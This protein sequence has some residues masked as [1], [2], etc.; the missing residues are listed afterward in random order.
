VDAAK[1][2]ALEAQS[3]HLQQQRAF[4]REGWAA[5]AQA[6]RLGLAHRGEKTYVIRGLPRN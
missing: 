5:E 3:S 1:V 6:R 4:T 2:Q